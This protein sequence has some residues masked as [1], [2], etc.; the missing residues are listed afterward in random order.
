MD[1]IIKIYSVQSEDLSVSQ[2]ILDFDIPEG[3]MYDLSRSHVL[4]NA[5]VACSSTEGG[6]STAVFNINGSVK[7]ELKN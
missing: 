1:K 4:L 7:V 5:K 3:E 2:N 6:F